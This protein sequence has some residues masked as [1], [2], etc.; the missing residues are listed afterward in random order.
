MTDI[1][2]LADKFEAL[3]IE[4]DKTF[5]SIEITLDDLPAHRL[6]FI[7]AKLAEILV[8]I[9]NIKNELRKCKRII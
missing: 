6:K 2:K 5:D 9:D 7:F 3:E 8:E 1:K 4:Y